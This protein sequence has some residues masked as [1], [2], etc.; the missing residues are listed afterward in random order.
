M[1]IIKKIKKIQT[2]NNGVL[3]MYSTRMHPK[4]HISTFGLYVVDPNNNSGAL[5][6]LV[7]T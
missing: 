2:I 7:T 3:L 5:Y 4:D 1:F 6:H